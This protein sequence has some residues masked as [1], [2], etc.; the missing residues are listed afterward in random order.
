MMNSRTSGIAALTLAALAV[1]GAPALAQDTEAQTLAGAISS[2]KG[3]VGIRY[4]YEYVGDDNP[5]L[6]KDTANASTVLLRMNYKTAPYKKFTAFGEFDYVGEILLSDFN[7]LSGDPGRSDYPVVADPKGPDLNQLY[8]DYDPN[9]DTRIRVGR[10]RILLDNERFVGGVGWRQNEQTYDAATLNMNAGGNTEFKYSFVN[11]VRRIVGSEV[12]GGRH[13]VNAHL[14]HAKVDLADSWAVTPYYYYLDYQDAAQSA[15]S[16]ATF[17]IRGTGSMP[18]GE[19]KLSLVGEF[20]NQTDIGNNPVGYNANYYHLAAEYGLKNGLSF[21][22]AYESLGGDQN[23][24]GAAFR[25]PLATLHA[26]QGW[27]DRFLA[28]PDAG[29]NDLFLTVKGKTGKW[30]LTGVYHDF[31]AEDGSADWGTELD[32]SAGRKLNDQIG[33]LL[34]AALYDAD[35][36]AADTTIFWVMFTGSY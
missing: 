27:A 14:L 12:D 18:V 30:N 35:Q 21:G 9:A 19:N 36:H 25:T 23:T 13:R 22:L 1:V 2:G 26:F 28:T 11:H 8:L 34:K 7:N 29:V 32:F 33:L 16:T 10:Q 17:G 20:A 6:V 5:L 15:L 24:A 31:S 3:T 4:R